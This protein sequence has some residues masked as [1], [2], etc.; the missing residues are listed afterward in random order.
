MWFCLPADVSA[1]LASV[2]KR[3]AAA[4]SSAAAAE[5]RREADGSQ[6]TQPESAAPLS[7]EEGAVPTQSG[8]NDIPAEDEAR[9]MDE[10]EQ[11]TQAESAAVSA[12]DEKNE[13]E[14]TQMQSESS[15]VA[16]SKAEADPST[17]TAVTAGGEGEVD[18][19]PTASTADPRSVAAAAVASAPDSAAAA[20]D[21]ETPLGDLSADLR[22][23]P[24]KG[25]ALAHLLRLSARLMVSRGWKSERHLYD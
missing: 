24:A 4:R 13:G 9:E 11:Q 10:G 7:A 3:L 18:V 20:P 6:V 1:E 2:E 5:E 21:D 8:Y 14:P 17:M 23:L 19:A 15:A 12:G 16:I 25:D 22:G